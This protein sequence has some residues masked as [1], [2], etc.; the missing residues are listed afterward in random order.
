MYEKNKAKLGT[1]LIPGKGNE[2]NWVE[3]HRRLRP[4]WQQA[5]SRG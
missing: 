3:V 1:V 5:I 4:D 2:S